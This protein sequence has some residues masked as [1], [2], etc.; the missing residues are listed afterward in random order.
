MR[1][2][3]GNRCCSKSDTFIKWANLLFE[4]LSSLPWLP[5]ARAQH[6]PR[7]QVE[8]WT[9]DCETDPFGYK[10]D[11]EHVPQPFI[12]GVYNGRTEEYIEFS[13]AEEMLDFFQHRRCCVYAHNGGKF[14]WHYLPKSR[15][16]TDEP[17]M[18]INGRMAKFR[19]GVAEFRDSLNIFQHTPLSKFGGKLEIDYAKMEPE[20]RAQHMEEI[21][22]Y[23]KA[24]C[25][26]LWRALDEYFQ[27]FGRGLTQAGSAMKVWSKMSGIKPPQQTKEQFLRY[28]PFF[29]G[30]RVEC[31]KTGCARPL[32]GFKVVDV[33]SAYPRAMLEKH[34]FSVAGEVSDTLPADKEIGRSL[35]RLTAISKGAFPYRL[36][37]GELI[38]P[39]DSKQREYA[40]T[41]WELVAALETGTVRQ[42]NI[43]EVHT[44]MLTV[45]FNDYILHFYDERKKHKAQGNRMLEQFDKYFMNGLY[46]KFGSNPGG[47]FTDFHGQEKSHG[48]YEEFVIASNESFTRWESQGFKAKERW[49]SNQLMV[50]ALPEER[51]HYY[52]V[53]TAASITGFQRATMLR[54]IHAAS[55]VIY[56]DTDSITAEDVSSLPQG[57]ELGQ[58]KVE[59]DASCYAVGGKKLY[60]FMASEPTQEYWGYDSRVPKTGPWKVASKGAKLTP[61]EIERV[62]NGE[63]VIYRP[64]VPTYSI[65]RELPQYI[66]RKIRRTIARSAQ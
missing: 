31:F 46:G 12:W 37:T 15:F 64:D 56:G 25:E 11:V 63:E 14:D 34:P 35:I 9:A 20:R 33:N 58:W 61:H 29:Y 51:H 48:G 53:A 36:E 44:F 28:K 47:I 54:G 21:K 3:Q 43:K 39:D 38:F 66:N 22:R 23:L 59:L 5:R 2:L 27:R 1:V 52:N 16:N 40:V 30:G 41:G 8:F 45:D 55:G 49:G 19:V 24:D 65:S 13:S 32:K 57:N 17:V 42:L 50:R 26:V 6:V 10:R 18:I 60:A 62:A 7:G 4:C